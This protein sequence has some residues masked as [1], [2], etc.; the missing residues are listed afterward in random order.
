MKENKLRRVYIYLNSEL[1]LASFVIINIS[2]N[3]S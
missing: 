2:I 1:K 3:R